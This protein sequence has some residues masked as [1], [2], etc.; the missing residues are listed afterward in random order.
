VSDDAQL[1]D[2]AAR[3]V[4]PPRVATAPYRG[5]GETIARMAALAARGA[6]AHRIGAS[7]TGEPMW[8]LVLGPERPRATVFVL[9]GLHAMEHVGVAAALALLDDALAPASR[10]RAH[11]LVVVPLGNPDGFRAACALAASGAR[12]FRRGNA[13]GVDLNR[14]FP[15]FWDDRYYL[16]RLAPGVFAPGPAPLSEPE[17][18]AIDGALARFTPT[19]AVSLHAFGRWIFVPY[20]GR[21]AAPRA[22]ERLLELGAAMAAAQARP[23]RV[24]QLGRRSRLFR[25]H[26]AEIDHMYEAHGALSALIEIGAG[27]RLGEPSTWTEPY[28]WYT[29]PDALLEDDVREAIA[30]VGGILDFDERRGRRRYDGREAAR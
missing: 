2:L 29:P 18:R 5:H 22:L 15:T 3:L 19:Y 6:T 27:P 10:W 9:A 30:A 12:G 23:Y 17:S 11:R 21:R 8:A 7:V 24:M 20:A 14:N 28:R 25:A 13:R 26:G 1:R 16:N 4:D